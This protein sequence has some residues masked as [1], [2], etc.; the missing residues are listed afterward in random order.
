MI[1]RARRSVFSLALALAAACATASGQK[2]KDKAMDFAAVKTVAVLP[3]QNLSRDNQAGDRIR[4]VFANALL[5]TGGVYVLPQGEV[6]RGLQKAAVQLP[7]TPTKEDAVNL[8]KALGVEAVITGTLKEYGEIR[9]G[10]ATANAISVSVE[11]LETTT[12]KV[13]WSATSTRG[14]IGVWDRLFGGGGEPMNK[15]S[16]EAVND[17]IGKLFK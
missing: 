11:M 2:Y 14:G 12:G 17:L 9:S 16:E 1:P 5:A 10:T 13:V 3:F 15:V 6:T 7:A 4:D 8:G